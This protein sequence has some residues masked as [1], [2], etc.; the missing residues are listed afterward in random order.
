MARVPGGEGQE[1][2]SW[3]SGGRARLG[4]PRGG[5]QQCQRRPMGRHLHPME[6]TPT[7]TGEREATH[8]AGRRR[9]VSAGNKKGRTKRNWGRPRCR[10]ARAA[11]MFGL[12]RPPSGRLTAFSG[13]VRLR[14]QR[15]APRLQTRPLGGATTR[16]LCTTQPFTPP[17]PPR[18]GGRRNYPQGVATTTPVDQGSATWT[19]GLPR[20]GRRRGVPSFPK[21]KHLTGHSH[22]LAESLAGGGAGQR[23]IRGGRKETHQAA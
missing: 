7:A 8:K 21:D 16:A 13:R 20:C 2:A 11:G 17:P 3:A 14:P 12:A 18:V 4:Q 9:T 6:R 1:S 23:H 15:D 10:A 19:R 22:L 5:A